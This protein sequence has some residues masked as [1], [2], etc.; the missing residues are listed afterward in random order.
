M[1]DSSG[2]VLK[3]YPVVVE[4]DEVPMACAVPPRFDPDVAPAVDEARGLR[5][6]YYRPIAWRSGIRSVVL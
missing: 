6:A 2:P 5:A 1:L 4:A 3:T